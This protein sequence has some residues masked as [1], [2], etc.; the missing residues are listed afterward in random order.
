MLGLLTKKQFYESFKGIF[1][2]AKNGQ[3]KS[4][5]KII[6]MVIL[7]VFVF[8]SLGFSFFGMSMLA[9]PLI[10]TELRWLFYALFG[11]ISIVLGVFVD[12]F[13]ASA[14][15]FRAKDN[16]LL[17]AMPINPKDIL[18]SRLLVLYALAFVYSGCCWLPICLNVWIHGT[19][20]IE[21][22]FGILLLFIISLFVT[23][24]SCVVGYLFA[25]ITTKAK[26]KT[27]ITLLSTLAI[28]GVYY[29]T[30]FKMQS[31]FESFVLNANQNAASL[32]S[33]AIII[34]FLG[35]GACGDV[36]NFVLFTLITIA[37]FVL[38]VW[39]LSK[40]FINIATASTATAKVS[41]EVKY[42]K[43]SNAKSALLRKELRHYANCPAYM[44]NTILGAFFALGLAVFAIIKSDQI[45]EICV[46][47][48]EISPSLINYIP[49]LII[50]SIM[51][52]ISVDFITAPSFSLEGKN[53][54]ILQ[55]LPVDTYDIFESKEKLNL[56][57]NGIPAI[58]AGLI[59]SYCF[60][61]DYKLILYVT[62]CIYLFVEAQGLF[63]LI[64]S[65]LRPN[66]SWVNEAQPVKQSL[67]GL[68]SMI[69]NLVS[70][71]AF[72]GLCY[73]TRNIITINNYLYAAIIVLIVLIVLMRRWLRSKGTELFN[74]L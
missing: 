65:I 53:L 23:V 24:L 39:I 62:I 50:V 49:V 14:Y 55:V 32:K 15:L 2:D 52:M 22:V 59:I 13:S 40:R 12:A 5:G 34:Y 3:L 28:L 69:F 21:V 68:F 1:I 31:L 36:L 71:I 27:L 26:N 9:S 45:L 33:F 16:D 44:I 25:K 48:N 4:K 51:L 46:L 30:S 63:G 41:K 38:L 8:L 17:L 57:A 56:I 20:I 72:G 11:I 18:I 19:T 64:V 73:L 29:F 35:K 42:K 61:L 37:L 66:F 60:K 70:L 6:G 67:N 43:Q 10:D 74:K 47:L 7:F 54:W 58:I